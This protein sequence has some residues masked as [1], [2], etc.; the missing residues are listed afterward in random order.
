[1]IVAALH[2]P[3]CGSRKV[4]APVLSIRSKAIRLGGTKSESSQNWSADD[5]RIRLLGGL[6]AGCALFTGIQPPEA[7]ARI[8]TDALLDLRKI[9]RLPSPE[10]L[11]GA[12]SGTYQGKTFVP[13]DVKGEVAR[14][15]TLMQQGRE[16]SLSGEYDTAVSLYSTIIREFPDL[17]V[18]EYARVNRALMLYQTDQTS[19]AILELDDEEVVL[20]G[21]AEV[22]SA[23]AA[24]LYAERP[25]QILRSEEQWDLAMSFD[26]RYGNPEWVEREKAWPPKMIK[27]L[28]KFLSLQ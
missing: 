20:R 22:H 5:F 14:I 11:I 28:N 8:P 3:A 27:A 10:V 17:A 15:M 2:R 7:S 23:L 1:M 13:E 16:A 25:S 24:I 21:N 19:R 9:P 6:L 4:A 12:Q 26:K 18:T